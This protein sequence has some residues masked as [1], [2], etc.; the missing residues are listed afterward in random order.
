MIPPEAERFLGEA[1][2]D[3]NDR[4]RGSRRPATT[5]HPAT[6][7]AMIYMRNLLPSG[8]PWFAFGISLHQFPMV[9]QTILLG[10]HPRVGLEDNIY[11]EKGKLAPS[12]AALVEKAANI[13]NIL[14]DNVATPAEARQILGLTAAMH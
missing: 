1:A 12:N 11:L 9:A 4:R 3:G 6:P 2:A 7:E 8:S 13:I 10:G 14:G 5:D